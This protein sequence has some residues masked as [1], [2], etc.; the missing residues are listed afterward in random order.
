M[1]TRATP[2]YITVCPGL[3]TKIGRP[4][5]PAQPMMTLLRAGR[6]GAAARAPRFTPAI[7]PPDRML[8]CRDPRVAG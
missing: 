5:S 6:A 8:V 4:D 3:C 1:G 7:V 2:L